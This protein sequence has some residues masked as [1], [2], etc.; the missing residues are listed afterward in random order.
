[1]HL[2]NVSKPQAASPFPVV[3]LYVCIMKS[4][5]RTQYLWRRLRIATTVLGRMAAL[6][7]DV[8]TYG[9]SASHYSL[10]SGLKRFKTLHMK[11]AAFVLLPHSRL[12]QVFGLVISFLLLWSSTVTPYTLS[13][14]DEDTSI[15]WEVLEAIINFLFACDLVLTFFSAYYDS[16][17]KLI[18]SKRQIALTYLRGWFA[19]DFISC[20]PSQLLDLQAAGNTSLRYNSFVRLIRLPRLYRLLRIFRIF[21][22]FQLSRGRSCVEF[23][24]RTASLNPGLLKL[25]KFVVL[26]ML[27]SHIVAC[28]WFLTAKLTDF[29]KDSWVVRYDLQDQPAA[30]LYIT[31]V[32]FVLTTIATVGFGDIVAYTMLE[33]C[34]AI[35]LLSIGVGFY[36]YAISNFS[37][38]MSSTD[39]KNL[40]L[41]QRLD[42]LADLVKMTKMPIETE[43]K[44]LNFLYRN[45]PTKFLLRFDREAVMKELPAFLRTEISLYLYHHY[46]QKV[47]FFQDKD[48]AF[49]A[50]VVPGLRNVLLRRG[51]CV[52]REHD[53]PEETFYITEGRIT[54]EADNRETFKTFVQGS[55]FGEIEIIA[56]RLRMATTRVVTES[57]EL[58]VQPK[59]KFLKMMEDFPKLAEEIKET[60]LLRCTDL[61]A[62][63]A[64]VLAPS[65]PLSKLARARRQTSVVQI[66]ASAEERMEPVVKS[67]L[68]HHAKDLVKKQNFRKMWRK[69]DSRR[70]SVEQPKASKWDTV[71]KSIFKD[72]GQYRKRKSIISASRALP[73]TAEKCIRSFVL[74]RYLREHPAQKKETSA[75]NKVR[76]RLPTL[77]AIA[78]TVPTR[79]NHP[80]L[81][82]EHKRLSIR[83]IEDM[84][85][86]L[87]P[88][89]FT[90]RQT[91][92]SALLLT[93]KSHLEVLRRQTDTLQTRLRKAEVG[94]ELVLAAWRELKKRT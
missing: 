73:L 92:D 77:V 41:S 31:S 19:V 24:M 45:L 56:G 28:L 26:G 80:I 66:E 62:R 79:T 33:R 42:A 46:V 57:A 78:K 44:V 63:K 5:A 10:K 53:F 43:K 67:R 76:Q 84:L 85:E 47:F 25:F 55:Y 34:Y 70:S 72:N 22:A 60:A 71:L 12:R 23:F 89:L 4:S 15:T 50:S 20:F 90:Q 91:H 21:K 14:L 49:I 61:E 32:Y 94:H 18:V 9:V 93:L 86:D 11:K 39:R 7:R 48:P 64:D 81:P 16:D 13:F 3:T 69:L 59:S 65:Q 51:D 54:F 37:T 8:H 52:Y 40:Y 68:W 2:P 83:G 88:A 1:M 17:N 82:H 38:M 58:L 6:S 29:D 27:L 74:E 30:E 87:D 75:W 35:C 36:S